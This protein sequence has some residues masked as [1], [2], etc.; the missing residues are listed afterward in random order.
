[1]ATDRERIEQ[2]ETKVDH[3]DKVVANMMRTTP[4]VLDEIKVQ[5]LTARALATAIVEILNKEIPTFD[6]QLGQALSDLKSHIKDS[7]RS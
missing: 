5:A 3:I 4:E 2:L 6:A 7:L 1:M